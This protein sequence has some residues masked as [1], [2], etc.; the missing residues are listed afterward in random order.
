MK[1]SHIFDAVFSSPHFI[2]FS[3]SP[4]WL[5]CLDIFYWICTYSSWYFFLFTALHF[6]IYWYKPQVFLC[7]RCIHSNCSSSLNRYSYYWLLLLLLLSLLLLILLGI[8]I[9]VY[10]YLHTFS[11]SLCLDNTYNK[12]LTPNHSQ[13]TA[14]RKYVHKGHTHIHT[15]ASSANKLYLCIFFLKNGISTLAKRRS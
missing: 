1:G 11:Y 2:F 8:V 13:T 12:V 6:S 7:R 3:S 9:F 4:F 5:V 15:N 14:T 10:D